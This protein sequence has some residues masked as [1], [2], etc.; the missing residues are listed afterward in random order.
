VLG[1]LYTLATHPRV[2][3]GT[4]NSTAAWGLCPDAWPDNGNVPPLMYVRE[5]PRLLGD[6]VATQNT[7]VRGACLHDSVGLGS[8]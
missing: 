3:P 8:W 4:R 5:G 7:L 2:P 1:Y 6:S